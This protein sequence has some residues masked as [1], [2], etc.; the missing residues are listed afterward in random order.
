MPH[1]MAAID[2]LAHCPIEP[3]AFGLIL[4]EAMACARPIVT[5]PVGGIP[6]VVDDGENGLLVAPRN[7]TRIAD[8][9]SRLIDD[10]AL[11]RWLGSGGAADR[12][13]A[14]QLLISDGRSGTVL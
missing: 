14:I 1:V 10:P 8:A 11:A 4:I 13:G 2:V 3:E 9:L 6:E 5:V 7:A 12:R